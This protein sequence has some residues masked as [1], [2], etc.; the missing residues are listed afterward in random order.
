MKRPVPPCSKNCEHRHVR[1]KTDGTCPN[2]WAEYEEQMREYRS[3][4]NG[5]KASDKSMDRHEYDRTIRIKEHS[6]K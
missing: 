3:L 6:W 5:N 2:G 4:V 1:C